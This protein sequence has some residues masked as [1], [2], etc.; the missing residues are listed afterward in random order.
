M[1]SSIFVMLSAF[2]F[3]FGYPA[4][5]LCYFCFGC[6]STMLFCCINR[7]VGVIKRYMKIQNP[8]SF[9]CA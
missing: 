3:L 1:L 4:F 2:F 6:N 9:L 7:C 8:L 5:S